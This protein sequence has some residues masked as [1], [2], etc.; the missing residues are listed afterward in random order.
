MLHEIGIATYRTASRPTSSWTT[1]E[2]G[3]L[4]VRC[5]TCCSS[6]YVL[7]LQLHIMLAPSNQPAQRP[8]SP[9]MDTD[10]NKIRQFLMTTFRYWRFPDEEIEDMLHLLLR[11][12]RAL[13]KTDRAV[14]DS[15]LG[16][17]F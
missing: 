8:T 10:L 2:V 17:T 9:P 11:N 12:R 5:D 14:Y 13:L 4:P 7:S 16:P 1:R 6:Q 3:P 15:I